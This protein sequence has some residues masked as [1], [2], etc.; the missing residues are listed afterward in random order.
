M[1]N[2]QHQVHETSWRNPVCVC[3]CVMFTGEAPIDHCG[4]LNFGQTL[5]PRTGPRDLQVIIAAGGCLCGRMPSDRSNPV[6]SWQGVSREQDRGLGDRAQYL[7][8]CEPHLGDTQAILE[9]MATK[10]KHLHECIELAK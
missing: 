10:C 5:H 8:A 6:Q 7:C 4:Y 1:N 2:T 3:G 9:R